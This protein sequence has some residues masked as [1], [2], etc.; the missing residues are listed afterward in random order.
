MVTT[1][2][3]WRPVWTS[4]S[5][6]KARSINPQPISSTRAIASSPATR[7]RRKICA[8][9]AAVVLPAVSFNDS[10]IPLTSKGAS[11]ASPKSTPVI[12]LVPSVKSSTR[13]SIEISS[14]RGMPPA[15]VS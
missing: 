10:E 8:P 15:L 9:A 14:A 11:G 12:K 5:F 2:S 13:Q 6:Q 4:C 3:A 7:M 1:F